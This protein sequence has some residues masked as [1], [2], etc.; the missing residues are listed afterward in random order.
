MYIRVTT[1]WVEKE[2]EFGDLLYI[3]R[4]S[5]DG[6]D[7]HLTL[8]PTDPLTKQIFTTPKNVGL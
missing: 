4:I 5:D 2:R 3:L 1:R 7:F 8:F 6:Y